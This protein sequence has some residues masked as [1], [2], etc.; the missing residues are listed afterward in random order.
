ME[1]NWL[2]MAGLVVAVA[3]LAALMLRVQG[4]NGFIRSELETARKELDQ[5]REAL[6]AKEKDLE[7]A[8][9]EVNRLKHLADG[10]GRDASRIP[11]SGESAAMKEEPPEQARTIVRR[12]EPAAPTQAEAAA[13][14]EPGESPR[15]ML[16]QPPSDD[17]SGDST[18]GAPYLQLG[19]GGEVHFLDFGTT[20]VG[21][22]Q[23]C[24]ITIEDA[25]ASR[26]HFEIMYK[27]NRFQLLDNNSTNGT[28]H[29]GEKV[30]QAWLE[31]G[32]TIRVGETEMTFSS[33]G[34]D[35]KDS[36]PS[37]AVELLETCVGRQPEFVSALRILAFLLERDVGR[38][39]EAAPLWEA[40]ARHEN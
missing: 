5:A 32:D 19:D 37:K 15:T 17:E 14:D 23:G 18:T 34:F 20:N 8:R 4:A 6:A 28:Q 33:E 1:L 39:G 35:L 13:T 7:S 29:N 26:S 10:S 11:A 30:E 12:A 36:D 3:V 16:Y 40:V 2:I 24:D 38:K 25:A 9:N 27:G 31:F 21:R 22:E